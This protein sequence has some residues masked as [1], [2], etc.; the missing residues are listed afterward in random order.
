MV[1]IP[2]CYNNK[3][4]VYLIK[5][6]ITG[7]YYVGSSVNIYRR[8]SGHKSK[9][10]ANKHSNQHLQNAINKYGIENFCFEI[11]ELCSKEEVRKKEGFYITKLKP[12]Y[13][14]DLVLETGVREVSEETR[15]KIGIK[16]AEKF[17]KNP[18][19][20]LKLFNS[21]KEKPVWNKGK[22]NIYSEETLEKMREKAKNRI[23]SEGHKKALLKAGDKAREK[24][25]KPVLQMDINNNVIKEW[26]SL[27]EAADN[28]NCKSA[29]N[30]YSGIKYNKIRYGYYWKYKE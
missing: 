19:L 12:H 10:L 6:K 16:S 11:L 20:K 9:L 8:S 21:R 2:H 25:K 28:F 29:G 1:L 18:E 24:R 13:N 4:G 15:L 3:C 23:Y 14:I 17:I 26:N 7:N 5:N 27:K 30:I 22:V